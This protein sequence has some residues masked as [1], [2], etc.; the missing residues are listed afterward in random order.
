MPKREGG[1]VD[2]IPLRPGDLAVD[3]LHVW[4]YGTVEGS[5]LSA[6]AVFLVG[7]EHGGA[8]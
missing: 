5:L 3:P 4:H 7:G 1:A 6:R 8:A 2:R